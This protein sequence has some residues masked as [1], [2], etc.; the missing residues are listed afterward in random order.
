MHTV[1]EFI[2]KSFGYFDI[3]IAWEGKG[4]DEVGINSKNGK[5]VVRIDP[6]YF[7]PT[8]VDL[9]LGDYTKAK[10]ALG[11]EPRVTF[12]ELVKVMI[13]ADWKAISG[14]VENREE[15]VGA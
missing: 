9:L 8:E 2:E 1:R 10:N 13:E 11:W 15:P 4:V 14:K 12:E 5:V 3:E 7:R 6:E